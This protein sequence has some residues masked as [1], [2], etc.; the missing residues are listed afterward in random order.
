MKNMSLSAR[1][2]A[3]IGSMAKINGSMFFLPTVVQR[4]T[5][6]QQDIWVKAIFAEEFGVSFPILDLSKLLNILSLHDDPKISLIG[7]KVLLI[8]GSDGR[9]FQYT[10]T[11]KDAIVIPPDEDFVLPTD[12]IVEFDMSVSA[13]QTVCKHT[14]V[15]DLSH[16][17]IKGDEKAVY[18]TGYNAKDGTADMYTEKM[19]PCDKKFTVDFKVHKITA[20]MENPYRVTVCKGVTRFVSDDITYW[21]AADTTSSYS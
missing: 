1:T 16:I 2:K 18:L 19:A 5:S 13:L 11:S 6:L 7:D 21:I 10:L 20:M 15:A 12:T 4:T 3:L 17:A 14:A 9:K 8:K